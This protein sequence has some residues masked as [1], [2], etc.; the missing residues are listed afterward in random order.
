MRTEYDHGIK[1]PLSASEIQS[2]RDAFSLK[3]IF[4]NGVATIFEMDSADVGDFENQLSI[5]SRSAPVTAV[6]DPTVNGYNVWPKNSPTFVPGNK[7]YGGFVKTWKHPTT[8]IEMLSCK[9]SKGDWLHVEIWKINESKSL[10]KL[11]TDKN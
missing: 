3:T 4:D 8:P 1:L 6:G 10:V 5:N 9:S 7:G 2:R 11:Y